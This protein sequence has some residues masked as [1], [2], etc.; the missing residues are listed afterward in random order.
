[1]FILFIFKG[2]LLKHF[3]ISLIFLRHHLDE[4]GESDTIKLTIFT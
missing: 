2:Q 1:M 4:V 3:H